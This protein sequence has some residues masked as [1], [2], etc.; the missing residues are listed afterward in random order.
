M[1]LTEESRKE[2]LIGKAASMVREAGKK[3]NTPEA[4]EFVRQ[5]YSNVP[6]NDILTTEPKDL[7]HAALSIWALARQRRAEE[8]KLK[9]FNP[10]PRKHGWSTSHTVVEIIND[11]MPFL[12]DSVTSE[13]SA[14]HGRRRFYL[15]IHPIVRDAIATRR[16]R[17]TGIGRLL[18]PET[19]P[20]RRRRV[21]SLHAPAVLGDQRDPEALQAV[22]RGDCRNHVLEDVRTDCATTSHSM[23]DQA[24]TG[25]SQDELRS[26]TRRRKMAAE[27]DLVEGDGPCCEWMTQQQLHVPRV[28]RIQ[29]RR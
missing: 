16:A 18:P 9:I 1:A 24:W 10:D 29:L 3:D 21:E 26:R 13:C 12:V 14:S 6:P 15:V 17:L 5:F 27:E 22:P 11:D 25:R 2:D 19:R 20:E 28:P 8:V 4:E 23:R 7:Y